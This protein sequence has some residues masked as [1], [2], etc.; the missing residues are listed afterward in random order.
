MR[1]FWFAVVLVALWGVASAI[2]DPV[3]R[4]Y[5]NDMIPSKQRA[6]VLSFDSLMGSGGGVVFQPVLGRVADV[7]GYGASMLWSGVIS[8][9]RR[10]LRADEQG[11]APARRHGSRGH[12]RRRERE[13]RRSG[14]GGVRA[15]TLR[16]RGM[17]RGRSARGNRVNRFEPPD[18]AS[19][20]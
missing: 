15:L 6:T 11:A 14:E 20:A 8:A 2:D 1:D 13:R 12:R 3:H 10:A 16:A 19:S 17:I 9:D 4:A 18:L 5:L 7:G